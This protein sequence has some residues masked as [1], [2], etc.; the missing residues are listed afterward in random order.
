MEDR[1]RRSL[2]EARAVFERAAEGDA[3]RQVA[4]I[5][6]RIVRCWRSGG[7][8]YACGN[9]GSMA[10]AM[11]FAEECTGRYLLDRDP[12]PAVALSDPTH[13]TCAANDYGFE[14]IFER[15]IRAIGRPGDA[16]LALSTSGRSENVV[17]AADAA[18]ARGMVVLGLLGGDGGPLLTRCDAWFLPEAVGSARIQELHLWAVHAILDAAER[19]LFPTAG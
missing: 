16:L 9:G 11:H 13:F 2:D 3:A 10:E 15:M 5:A 6:R 18:K 4:E 17:R 14:S 12:L 19:E 8:V 1:I 7:V